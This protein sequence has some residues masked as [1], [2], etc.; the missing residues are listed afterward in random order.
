[1]ITLLLL[2]L[3]MGSEE[4]EGKT[5]TVDDGGEGDY[6]TIESAIDNAAEGDTIRV[7]AGTY[8]E[9][10]VVDK[11]VDLIGNGS[12]STTID[13]GGK[14]DVV[15]ITADGV[16]LS[17]FTITGSGESSRDAGILV[18]SSGC[19]IFNNRCI[20]NSYGM[21]LDSADETTIRDNNCSFNGRRGISLVYS[22]NCLIQENNCSQ[23]GEYG[24]AS[25]RLEGSRFGN[26]SC[27]NNERDGIYL[28]SSDHCALDW[29]NCS[30][31]M[32][33]G[34]YLSLC[35]Y[36]LL[37]NNSC[38]RNDVDGLRLS[39]SDK[40]EV[41]NNSCSSNGANGLVL[42]FCEHGTFR[43]NTLTD[44]GLS[45]T[46]SL[47]EWTTHTMDE[48]NMIDGESINYY[49]NVS[50]ELMP[51]DTT[52]LILANCSDIVLDGRDLSYEEDPLSVGYSRNITISNNT[53]RDNARGIRFEEVEHSIIRDNV[54]SAIQGTG[55]YL[56][57]SDHN[58]IFN[59]TVSR[60]G[61]S[62]IYLYGSDDSIIRNNTILNSEGYSIGMNSVYN[63]LFQGNTLTNGSYGLFLKSSHKN[64]FFN[65]SCRW[66]RH[67]AIY[68]DGSDRNDLENNSI[69]KS[70]NSMT[71]LD[72]HSNDLIGNTV[73][74]NTEG[75]WVLDTYNN[76]FEDNVLVGA[77]IYLNT[78]RAC[79]LLD[80][81]FDEGGVG[82]EGDS[83]EHWNTHVIGSSNTVDGQPV[84]YIVNS[85]GVKVPADAGQVL[86]VNSS[87]IVVED[88][89]IRNCPVGVLASFSV[90]VTISN[91]NCSQG[92]DGV[93]LFRSEQ[94]TITSTNCTG[95]SRNGIYLWESHENSITSVSGTNSKE[96]GMFLLGS[97][98]NTIS[99]GNFSANMGDGLC[100]RHS[101]QNRFSGCQFN[102]NSGNG[103][104]LFKSHRTVLAD[105]GF[106]ENG[107]RGLF[108]SGSNFVKSSNNRF[109]ETGIYIH[110]S[111]TTTLTFNRI[112]NEGVDLW[113]NI[114]SSANTHTI[115]SS[116]T[117]NGNPIRYY[118]NSSGI[119]VPDG[120]GQVIL[121]NCDHMT[122]KD[123]T[124]NNTSTPVQ[125]AFSSDCIITD[126]R[127]FDNKRSGILFY[128]SE[129][130]GI[131]SSNC[132]GN[133][134]FGVYLQTSH[135][136]TIKNIACEDNEL[137]LYLSMARHNRVDNSSF[138]GN[139]RGVYQRY[140]SS[141]IVFANNTIARNTGEGFYLSMSNKNVYINNTISEN[142]RG[143]FLEFFSK[144]NTLHSNDI[145]ENDEYGIFVD[146]DNG[147]TI[148]ATSNWW[149]DE[150]GPYHASK[151]PGGKGD[152]VTDFVEF[153][154]W[155]D[156]SIGARTIYVDDDAPDGGN[157]SKEDPYNRIQDAIDAAEEG[158]TIR[159][160]QGTYNENVLVNRAVNVVGNGSGL[161]VIHG[162]RAGNVV[163][164]TSDWVNLS[165][166]SMIY[167]GSGNN[168]GIKIES[169][170]NTVESNTCSANTKIGIWL[171]GTSMSNTIS[172]NNCSDNTLTGIH[173]EGR[174][175]TIEDNL[176][177]D[178]VQGIYSHGLDIFILNNT[179]MFNDD[180][181]RLSQGERCLV[182]GNNCS[183]N[184]D[185][186]VLR[187]TSNNEISNNTCNNNS[188]SG[189]A[190][191]WGLD[192]ARNNRIENNLCVN[193]T[194]GIYVNAK[195]TIFVKNIMEHCGFY[196][197]SSSTTS[198]YW[199]THTMTGNMVNNKPVH[200]YAKTSDLVVPEHAGQVIIAS[201][202]NI[203]VE[204]Q[205]LSDCTTGLSV[206]Y[207]AGIR[208]L[209]NSC[210]NN[211][212]KSTTNIWGSMGFLSVKESVIHN[213]SCDA[214]DWLGVYMRECSDN[215]ITNNSFTRS[216]TGAYLTRVDDNRLENN[217]FGWN[218]NTG[219]LLKA[220]CDRNILGNNSFLSNTKKGL[221]I[222]SS[223]NSNSIHG[224]TISGSE[225]GIYQSSSEKNS[226]KDNS[227]F[228]NDVGLY[229]KESS[230]DNHVHH[231]DIYNNNNYGV[232]ANSNNGNMVNC[233]NNWWRTP[234]GPY[235]LIK[236]PDGKGD[237]VSENVEFEPWITNPT[238]VI[239]T[240][241][242][243]QTLED[244]VYSV[245]YDA[246][247]KNNDPLEWSFL[248]NASFLDF[249]GDTRYLNGTPQQKD[250]GSYWVNVSVSDGETSD[251]HNFTLTVVEVN[252]HPVIVNPHG[253]RAIP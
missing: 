12:A 135:Y 132:S 216:A 142:R 9:N 3:A 201:S 14:G 159:V 95:N 18:E 76:R 185:G 83:L 98:D 4:N 220:Y 160:W 174:Y 39:R 163:R 56:S 59:N 224:N 6:T 70:N 212:D 110:K 88:Q 194:Y 41:V 69:T 128:Q 211:G 229:F 19:T 241:D 68:L 249:H 61:G 190:I 108:I 113:P 26:N 118:A 10:V 51:E 158:D 81:S 1:M 72:S 80:N 217:T 240:K 53:F 99:R 236:N 226:F 221:S 91:T 7:W 93:L 104:L 36:V 233:S 172:G 143:L 148:N 141:E 139:T 30:R 52:N 15:Q 129:E 13:G 150:S 35:D 219:L 133:G 210:N 82:L 242:V 119:T 71:L 79:T 45:L 46:G 107:N 65:N 92:R 115:D 153:A 198:D 103:T 120:A 97:D 40:A 85:S 102:E 124:F 112:Q 11:A 144:E 171:T 17:G 215:V 200:Y 157:G 253:N 23:N 134:E 106:R 105:S 117:V 75:V 21:Y 27:W 5:I 96:M 165:G 180:G 192:G 164:I 188:D 246:E 182:S 209:N 20:G 202:T 207:S 42:A 84:H 191:Y 245:R 248:S 244:R 195:K 49:K 28:A 127:C 237:N 125:L 38:A 147:Y 205:N 89:E 131:R 250:V 2:V 33:T 230:R 186:I 178:N 204:N 177:L 73:S 234:S 173:V 179:V 170:F 111:R 32:N 24:I 64:L 121:A 199:D 243:R 114:L 154:P 116:N 100:L 208:I 67:T 247:D 55:I 149:G 109:L 54:F 222:Q 203:T 130:N 239:T 86:I 22:S 162:N 48:T 74:D 235:H 90:N 169:S 57:T 206:G 126:V 155:L 227:I 181:I 231:N 16:N 146:L 168:A 60:G 77:S 123:Q 189:I 37:G 151:N 63:N 166:F 78:S 122:I 251:H 196:I 29:N 225:N 232:D 50:A 137:G 47:E 228:G 140:D 197:S 62:G 214:N 152:R 176:C 44:D 138:S 183:A 43:G 193:D 8:E 218:R 87:D 101:E 31:N 175:N 213:N 184:G 136:N 252:E 187:E 94:C 161:S 58:H 145:C 25:Y 34:I 238:P 156:K 223:S 167:G 66:S